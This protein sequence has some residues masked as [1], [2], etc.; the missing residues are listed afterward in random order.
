MHRF[1]LQ[2]GIDQ[3]ELDAGWGDVRVGIQTQL[4][5]DA[6]ALPV[7]LLDATL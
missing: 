2:S 1:G 6:I 7:Q 4:C 3:V 5:F